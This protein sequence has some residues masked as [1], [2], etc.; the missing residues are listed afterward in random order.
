M[1]KRIAKIKPVQ[2]KLVLAITTKIRPLIFKK[3]VKSS[4]TIR[5]FQVDTIK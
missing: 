5:L 4:E 2:Y 1:A 3:A